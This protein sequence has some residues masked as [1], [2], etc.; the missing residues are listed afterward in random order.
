M[1]FWVG[2]SLHKGNFRWSFGSVL[3]HSSVK[4]NNE[5]YRWVDGH[6]EIE[7]AARCVAIS[8]Y[9]EILEMR[10]VACNTK[11]NFICQSTI[12][13]LVKYLYH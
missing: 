11:L 7:R 10:A 9:R 13:R 5:T 6:P 1:Q 2:L 3:K 12:K 8:P 4:I